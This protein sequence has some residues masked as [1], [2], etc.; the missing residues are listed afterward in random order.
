[1]EL[2][3]IKNKYRVEYYFVYAGS[4]FITFQI[5]KK[6]LLLLVVA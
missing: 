4:L 3:F 1:M 6:T 5:D 2:F